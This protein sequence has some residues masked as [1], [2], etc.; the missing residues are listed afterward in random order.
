MLSPDVYSEEFC[1]EP[2]SGLLVW[3]GPQECGG[4]WWKWTF[5]GYLC[6]KGA[7][8]QVCLLRALC[9]QEGGAQYFPE[10]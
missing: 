7:Q 4:G 5:L 10:T 6:C 8:G 2:G 1:R 9:S 3:E